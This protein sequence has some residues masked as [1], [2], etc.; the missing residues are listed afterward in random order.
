[1]TY[2]ATA[3]FGRRGMMPQASAGYGLGYAA[4]GAIPWQCWDAPGFKDCH[5]GCYEESRNQCAY[6]VDP[7]AF[8]GMEECI[9]RLT[10]QCASSRCVPD[11]CPQ[12]MPSQSPTSSQPWWVG[13]PCKNADVVRHVQSIIGTKADGAWGPN[14]QKAYEQHRRDGGESYAELAY[15]CTGPVPAKEPAV[16][17]PKPVVVA[18][19]P[20]PLPE[21]VVQ[22]PAKKTWMQ[23][24]MLAVGGVVAAL[25]VGGYIYAKKKGLVG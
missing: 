15:G 20:P 3:R 2:V 24:N 1:M 19:P 11:L 4:L 16:V 13:K 9:K 6:N 14:S 10:D 7:D 21:P 23:A 25:G 22:A 8:G 12:A 18:P 17:K 5:A